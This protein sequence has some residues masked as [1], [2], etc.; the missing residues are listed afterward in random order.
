MV[1]VPH[2]KVCGVAHWSGE[3]HQ[4]GKAPKAESAPDVPVLKRASDLLK[5]K[6]RKDESDESRKSARRGGKESGVRLQRPAL[7]SARDIAKLPAAS[8]PSPEGKPAVAG[9]A[10]AGRVEAASLLRFDRNAYQREYMRKKRE[11]DKAK[12]GKT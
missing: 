1:K 4:F 3:G 12:K 10:D 6:E 9:P 5:A 8:A 7:D 2:C 11:A